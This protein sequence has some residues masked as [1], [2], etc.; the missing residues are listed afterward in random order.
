MPGYVELFIR[1]S[2]ITILLPPATPDQTHANTRL[3]AE[4]THTH[5]HT[6]IDMH[7]HGHM[8]SF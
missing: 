1:L 2:H 7:A 3:T 8:N 6:D 4:N 5:T